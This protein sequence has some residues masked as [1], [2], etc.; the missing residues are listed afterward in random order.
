MAC[1]KQLNLTNLAKWSNLK[2]IG[3]IGTG[4][5]LHPL[6]FSEIKS[7]LRDRGDGILTLIEED[8][9]SKGAKFLLTTEV[10]CIYSD[11]GKVKRIHLLIFLPD[12][13][14]VEAL[15]KA[16]L[17]RGARLSSDGRPILGMSSEALC[18]IVFATCPKAIIIPAHIY[19]PW[20]SL[21]GANS[22]YDFLAECF[23][24]FTKEIFAVETG[25][26]S[27][28]AMNWRIAD[29]DTVSIVSFSDPHSLPRIGREATVFAGNLSFDE[30]RDDLK[31]QN[32]AR[33]IEFYPEYGKYHFSGHR[34]CH[35][36][37]TPAQVKKQ[38]MI[39]PICHKNLTPGVAQRIEELATRSQDDLE[40]YKEGIITKSKLF[41][42]RP[43]FTM[44]VQLEDIIAEVL[45][46][47]VSS[48]KVKNEYLRLVTTLGNEL[49]I[50]TSLSPSEMKVVAGETL[51]NAIL[52]ARA[53][54][55]S[56]TPGFDNSYGTVRIS[57]ENSFSESLGLF[58][59]L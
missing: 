15:S 30:L 5:F 2:G 50:L 52:R 57:E 11:G 6:Y 7:Q 28:P 49:S 55:V 39:C 8:P 13:K 53:G 37:L 59:K 22:G 43:G 35:V 58:D 54:K 18:G 12:L 31:N 29:L 19:T 9:T 36:S 23:K 34:K 42:E 48:Q 33:T 16:L 1:S 21:Y 10:A 45:G 47:N 17:A 20:F 3:L 32:L 56:I 27:N 46:S 44:L 4:D 41:P 24:G 38:G 26:S 25:I 40:I 14:S 51:T